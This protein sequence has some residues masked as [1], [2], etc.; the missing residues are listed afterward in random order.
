MT[1]LARRFPGNPLLGPADVPP[2][3]PGLSVIGVLNPGAFRFAGRTWLLL[4]VAEGLT[5]GHGTVSAPVLDP[6]APDG[7]RVVEAP[8]G[9]PDLVSGDPR[10]FVWCGETYL[11]TISHLRLASSVDG[12]HFSVEPRPAL[13]GEGALESYGI[14]DGRVSQVGERFYLSYTAVSPYGFGVGLASTA[15]WT[16][17]DRHGM[18][19]APPNKDC[20]LFPERI[21]GAYMALHRPVSEGL[22]GQY[23]WIASS[24]DLVH[25]GDHR[26][27]LRP[28]RGTWDAVKVGAGA[29][30]LRIP[31]GWLEIY[32]GVDGGNR[33]CLGAV[34]LDAGDPAT[35]LGRSRDPIME[36][37]AD[38]ER[39][40]F[41][42]NVVFGTGVVADGDQ[43]TIYY[44]AAD[45]RVCGATMS[46]R[47]ILASLA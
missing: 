29:P 6:A 44:G 33:Y 27:V 38:Y 25:W 47:E 46:I 1:D 31:E 30:P 41:F 22:G 3:R 8:E 16:T 7:L 42:G 34:L 20:V 37:L 39:R 4:R 5:A 10:S 45:D 14:E 32:H 13:E 21:G 17:F 15:D 2:S 24:P 12:V 18:A 23:M 26:C 11:T 36:P 9:D 43:L 35:V 19:F 40:G 28:R